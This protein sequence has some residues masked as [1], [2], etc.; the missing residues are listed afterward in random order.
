MV[1]EISEAQ[2]RNTQRWPQYRPRAV[3]GGGYDGE[4]EALKEWLDIR[5]TWINSQ[6]IQ[7]PVVSHFPDP[8]VSDRLVVLDNPNGSGA[9]Y[10]TLDGS[11]P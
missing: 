10:Y 1:E 4:I 5:S 9:I 3:Y 6:F 2:P 8:Q 7:P 11:D